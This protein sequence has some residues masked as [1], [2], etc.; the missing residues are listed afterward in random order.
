M[1][2]LAVSSYGRILRTLY[3]KQGLPWNVHDE[4]VRIDPDVRHLVPHRPEPALFEFLKQTIRP[5]DVVLDVG[6][7]VGIYAVLAA[8]W[9][10][11]DGRVIAFEPTPASAAIARK[12]LAFNGVGPERVQ[13]VEAAVSNRATRA[14]LHQY[15][16]HAMPYVNSLVEAVDTNAP[17]V[18]RDVAVVTI[19]E[20]CRELKVLPSVIRMDVQGAE[21]HALG[22]ARETIRGAP[23]LSLV[24]E[25]HPQ[26]WPA[27]G[28]T[29]QDARQMLRDLG[30]T[31][32]PL[33]AGE[34]LFARDTH[35][36][37]SSGSRA[38]RGGE[39]AGS[40]R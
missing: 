14:T 1:R 18:T 19:D 12:H 20:I 15:D 23:H 7:F 34:E 17:A 27:F 24:V 30:L 11:P 31:A 32:R 21:I 39:P 2:S 26:C 8:R 25:M 3:A 10:G 6:A 13:L 36:V 40:R 38:G 16:A 4:I 5:G 29:E 9:S 37:L 28:V 33:V 35:A 22:G